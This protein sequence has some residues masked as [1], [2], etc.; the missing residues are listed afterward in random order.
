MTYPPPEYATYLFQPRKTRFWCVCRQRCPPSK[1]NTKVPDR[2][3]ARLAGLVRGCVCGART[4]PGKAQGLSPV[5]SACSASVQL[6]L[7][8][9]SSRFL[10]YTA[11]D[12][13]IFNQK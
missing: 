5:G 3:G 2:L 11:L 12:C 4:Q 8:C 10:Y 1:L 6:S 9:V 13:Y 7:C